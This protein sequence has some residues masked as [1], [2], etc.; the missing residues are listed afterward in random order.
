MASP[1]LDLER[2]AVQL[3]R[4]ASFATELA[5]GVR[6]LVPGELSRKASTLALDLNG[7]AYRLGAHVLD[8]QERAARRV[9]VAREQN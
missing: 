8:A 6:V 1:D 5:A 9:E 3:S 7:V 2:L 4:L